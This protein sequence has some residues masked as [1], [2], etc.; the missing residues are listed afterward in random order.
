MAKHEHKTASLLLE[1]NIGF[2]SYE[3]SLNDSTNVNK[4]NVAVA[5]GNYY[6]AITDTK[7]IG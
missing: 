5:M 3:L 7:F 2:V 4:V 6:C 1:A